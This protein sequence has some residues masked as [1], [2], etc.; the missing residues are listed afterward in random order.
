LSF[1]A[2]GKLKDL[3]KDEDTEKAHLEADL[4]LRKILLELGY[5][6]VIELYDQIDK[7]YA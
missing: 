2:V 1:D 3:I 4:T 5:V 7:W 6:E